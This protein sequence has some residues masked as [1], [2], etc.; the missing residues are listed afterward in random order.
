VQTTAAD[1]RVELPVRDPLAA[2][3]DRDSLAAAG[4]EIGIKKRGH[5]LQPGDGR[6]LHQS[7]KR[8]ADRIGATLAQRGRRA[9][10]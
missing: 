4:G 5:V 3:G 7:A 10:L 1:A 9:R 8:A 6:G 2:A